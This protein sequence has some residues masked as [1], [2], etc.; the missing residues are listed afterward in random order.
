MS[1]T[2]KQKLRRAIRGKSRLIS[3]VFVVIFSWNGR[4]ARL[5]DNLRVK[6]ADMGNAC[7]H[8]HHFATLI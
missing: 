3:R 1:K 4:G 7:W 8:N 6:I 2:R 5:T